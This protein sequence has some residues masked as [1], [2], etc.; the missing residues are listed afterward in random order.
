MARKNITTPRLRGILNIKDPIELRQKYS[1]YVQD[2]VK[3]DDILYDDFM[4]RIKKDIPPPSA[5]KAPSTTKAPHRRKS[6]KTAPT[7]KSRRR[8]GGATAPTPS[9][10]RRHTAPTAKPP[11]RRRR[12]ST[13]TRGADDDDDNT[14]EKIGIEHLVK[15]IEA[16]L[17]NHTPTKVM[18][19][20]SFLFKHDKNTI[21]TGTTLKENTGLKTLS[22]YTLW[23]RSMGQYK[24]ILGGDTR[25]TY[26]MNP[27]VR[28]A[29]RG[30]KRGL[31]NF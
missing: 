13:P 21:H 22:H 19:L 12:T 20:L 6:R 3:I 5:T 15:N 1:A 18:K 27:I 2:V 11:R 4:D 23:K 8:G 31:I 7:A 17:N 14:E 10:R 24:V 16:K 9:H 28:K 25:G 29:L 26:K 30:M